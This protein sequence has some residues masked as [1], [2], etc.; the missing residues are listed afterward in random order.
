[1]ID[2]RDL[3]RQAI[4]EWGPAMQMV[5]VMEECGELTTAVAQWIRGR[6]EPSDVAEEI[7]DVEIM[8]G[9]LR[10]MIGSELVDRVKVS[11]LERLR[12]RVAECELDRR[13]VG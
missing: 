2:D 5:M 10:E 13:G 7:A 3:Y 9:Q 1:M 12:D 11:K 6:V 8:C 4:A